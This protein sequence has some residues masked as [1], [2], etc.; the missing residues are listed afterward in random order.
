MQHEDGG[1]TSARSDES[2]PSATAAPTPGP[3]VKRY[4]AVANA[5][6]IAAAPSLLAALDQILG[7]IWTLDCRGE[8]PDEITDE[9]I[10]QA[11]KAVDSA[12]GGAR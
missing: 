2:A 4:E 7:A 10:H 1:C 9:M 3:W 5:R 12:T 6:L 11:R 8:A